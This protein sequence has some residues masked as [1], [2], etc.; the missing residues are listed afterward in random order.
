MVK[1]VSE[2]AIWNWKSD[3]YMDMEVKWKWKC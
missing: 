2:N 1:E 3:C